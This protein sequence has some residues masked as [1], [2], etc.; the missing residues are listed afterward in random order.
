[1]RALASAQGSAAA[2][3]QDATAGAQDRVVAIQARLD[4]VREREELADRTVVDEAEVGRALGE[5]SELWSVLASPERERVV[6]LVLDRVT[7]GPD[8]TLD[9]Q[10]ALHGLAELAEETA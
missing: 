6:R 1:M 10:F 7:L 8:G 4:D 3:L 2:A 9:I 5:F